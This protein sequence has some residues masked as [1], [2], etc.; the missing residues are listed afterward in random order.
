MS[1]PGGIASRVCSTVPRSYC[2]CKSAERPVLRALHP[3]ARSFALCLHELS[4][5]RAL[6][7][8]SR[9]LRAAPSAQVEEPRG[10]GPDEPSKRSRASKENRSQ[11]ALLG[12]V[13][14]SRDHGRK[15][16][17]VAEPSRVRVHQ[18]HALPTRH[19]HPAD[20]YKRVP[21]MTDRV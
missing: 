20:R 4:L 19:E 21:R 8:G 3:S 13:L 17:G 10:L 7:P 2:P 14:G 12:A 6:K 11:A 1:I 16:R 5:C 18:G 9:G 15:G